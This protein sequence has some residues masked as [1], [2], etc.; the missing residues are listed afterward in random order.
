MKKSMKLQSKIILL[1]IAVVFVSITIIISFVA[2]W[3][4]RNIENEARINI[5]NVAKLVAHSSEVIEALEEQN[6]DENLAFFIN[7]QLENLE[8]VDHITVAD[9]D[10]KRKAHPGPNTH[11]TPPTKREM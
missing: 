9:K 8:L 7:R 5:M 1:V 6:P 2:S 10:G 3:M 4:T 11:N